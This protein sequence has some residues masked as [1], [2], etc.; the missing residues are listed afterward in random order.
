LSESEGRAAVI[1]TLL[2]HYRPLVRG[3]RLRQNQAHLDFNAIL[4][5]YKHRGVKLNKFKALIKSGVVH[6]QGRPPQLQ[7]SKDEI[8]TLIHN[9]ADLTL[10]QLAQKYSVCN[11]TMSKFLK[12]EGLKLKTTVVK[13]Q[14]RVTAANI[15]DIEIL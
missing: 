8:L 10:T 14:V 7:K 3:K 9:G 13:D 12:K 15:I 6:R 4:L 11:T 2:K 1:N 5:Q